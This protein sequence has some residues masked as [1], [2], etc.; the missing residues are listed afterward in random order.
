MDADRGVRPKTGRPTLGG[1]IPEAGCQP[2]AARRPTCALSV[3][4]VANFL[5]GLMSGIEPRNGRILHAY[6]HH[7]D[8]GYVAR[9]RCDHPGSR[10]M[11]GPLAAVLASHGMTVPTPA[12][13]YWFRETS[14]RAPG[15]IWQGPD[16]RWHQVFFHIGSRDNWYAWQ[17]LP[18]AR[19]RRVFTEGPTFDSLN[20]AKLNG[21][22]YRQAAVAWCAAHPELGL[23]VT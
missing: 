17:E 21:P 18:V 8:L 19:P 2:Q 6:L 13:P 20:L 16:Y 9:R 3:R 12:T 4:P 22:A 14:D 7:R 1:K 5:V 23:E 10:P 15:V 11:T